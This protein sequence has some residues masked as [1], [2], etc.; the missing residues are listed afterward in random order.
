M[1]RLL[2]VLALS[3]TCHVLTPSLLLFFL[4]FVFGSRFF[5]AWF[6]GVSF[7]SMCTC[8]GS[9]CSATL[10]PSSKRQTHHYRRQHCVYSADGS[11]ACQRETKRERGG[12]GDEGVERPKTRGRG[13]WSAVCYKIRLPVDVS[14]RTSPASFHLHVLL[15]DPP[16]PSP[17]AFVCRFLPPCPLSLLC[18]DCCVASSPRTAPRAAA[19]LDAPSQQRRATASSSTGA[20]RAGGF[21]CTDRERESESV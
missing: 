21:G 12:G 9:R 5:M 13:I 14:V 20:A 2:L 11:V 17:S 3:C 4:V 18:A 6:D 10:A 7:T 8:D 19:S 15:R 16:L 1:I